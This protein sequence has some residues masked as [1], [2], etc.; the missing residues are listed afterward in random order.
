LLISTSIDRAGKSGG[1][2]LVM[3]QDDDVLIA[4]HAAM[5]RD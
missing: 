4:A 1:T 2:I 5:P 3:G